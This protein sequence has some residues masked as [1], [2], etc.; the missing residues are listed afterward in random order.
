MAS[1]TTTPPTI[2]RTERGLSISG[3]R[4]TLYDLMDYVTAKYPPHFIRG[5]FDLSEAQLE[6][7]LHY[8]QENRTLVEAEYQQ[9]L[10]ET[11]ELRKYYDKLSRERQNQVSQPTP[12]PGTE[13]AWEKLMALREKRQPTA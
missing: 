13:A 12:K 9:V 4:I 11:E 8:I 5:L 6:V 1:P 7:A 2:V 3:T 10:Q